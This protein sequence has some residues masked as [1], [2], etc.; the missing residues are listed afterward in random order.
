MIRKWFD[1]KIKLNY[2]WKRKGSSRS[3]PGEMST[4]NREITK[5]FQ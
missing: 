5:L 1:G 2:G 3:S 4:N